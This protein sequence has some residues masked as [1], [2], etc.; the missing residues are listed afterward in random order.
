M[1]MI[2]LSF[3][4]CKKETKLTEN[5]IRKYL[6]IQAEYERIE[7]DDVYAAGVRLADGDTHYITFK[8]APKK[9]GTFENVS[10]EVKDY[11]YSSLDATMYDDEWVVAERDSSYNEDE[12]STLTEEI[13]LPTDGKYTS[14]KHKVIRRGEGIKD[15]EPNT[16]TFI[17]NVKGTFIEE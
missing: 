14:G 5:N 12:P 10:F 3:S 2:C 17:S 13:E 16:D 1:T 7:G 4:G 8:I 6:S 9:S 15:S 11:I